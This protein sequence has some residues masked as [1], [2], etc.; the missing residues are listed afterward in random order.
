MGE[1]VP[2]VTYASD[3]SAANRVGFVGTDNWKRGRTA[4][5]STS[6]TVKSSGKVVPLIGSNRYQCQDV[7]DAGFRSYL[8]ENAPEFHVTETL[9]ERLLHHSVCHHQ[10]AALKAKGINLA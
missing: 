4:A 6:Q 8:R 2:V 3:L 7:A 10:R 5:C 1:D 9:R